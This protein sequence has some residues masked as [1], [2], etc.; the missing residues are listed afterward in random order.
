LC[1]IARAAE[2]D[3]A[4]RIL[5]VTGAHTKLVYQRRFSNDP[6]VYAVD[7]K[8]HML[9][10]FDTQEGKERVLLPGPTSCVKPSILSDG[11]GVVYTDVPQRACYY[12][13]WEGKNPPKLIASGKL[14]FALSTWQDPKTGKHWVLVGDGVERGTPE[15]NPV[16]RYLI[17]DPTQR[18]LVWDKTSV[19][20]CLRLS[21]DGTRLGGEF[22]WP[23]TGVANLLTGT[24]V[25]HGGGCMGDMAPDN[26]YRYAHC[27]GGHRALL[28]FDA[29]ATGRRFVSTSG[30]P[31][32]TGAGEN[33]HPRWSNDVRFMTMIAPSLLAYAAQFPSNPCVYLGKYDITFS[34]IE[35]WVQLTDD[36]TSSIY[37]HA[38][39]EPPPNQE[40]IRV[41]EGRLA[42]ILETA[43]PVAAIRALQQ[44]VAEGKDAAR[45][46]D[47]REMLG[48]FNKWSEGKLAVGKVLESSGP[49]EA[50]NLYTALAERY[51]G[52]ELG[53]QAA[54]RLKLL[55][56]SWA[57]ATKRVSTLAQAWPVSRDGLLFR[58]ATANEPAVAL[59]DKDKPK[60]GFAL[61]AHGRARL[62]R[63]R[64]MVLDGGS[65]YSADGVEDYLLRACRQ[66][67]ALTIQA[68]ITPPEGLPGMGE[69]VSFGVDAQTG[70]FALADNGYNLNLALR[71]ASGGAGWVP[72]GRK[73]PGAF[74]VA[75]TYTDGTLLVYLNGR[76]FEGGHGWG[77]NTIITESSA[78]AHLL[79]GG[80]ANWTAGRLT[81]GGAPDG[82]NAWRGLLEGVAIFNRALS[83]D[84]IQRDADAYRAM[85][86]ARNDFKPV[87]M[88]RAKVKLIARSD[89]PTIPSIAPYSRALVVYRYEVEDVHFGTLTAK[90]L[91]VA[92]WVIMDKQLLGEANAGIGTSYTMAL[93]PFSAQP[94]LESEYLVDTLN[95][96][97]DLYY[98][99]SGDFFG[100]R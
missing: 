51:A 76:R 92:R 3:L 26:S 80:F 44:S 50:V 18:V 88:V 63:S 23:K 85:V 99:T 53:T 9:V 90:N 8:N 36:T 35:Q 20:L 52:L 62:G 30:Y 25:A 56:T 84:E 82:K 29:G 70:N 79:T 13:D 81:F 72:V 55:D 64:H 97:D 1:G 4:A 7:D 71:T 68:Y 47:A 41:M 34:R 38:W 73:P 33:W 54:G 86:K 40:A 83:A 98:D 32:D 17:D 39:I 12:I 6:K 96:K 60:I 37:P 2:E 67:G 75:L 43:D 24:W 5:K 57:S 48:L 95:A 14:Y 65:W 77:N 19:G 22:P 46:N 78:V 89:I 10:V 49:D 16:Y 66:T 45:V 69:I 28:M 61:T 31:G 21:A 93:E 11:S 42:Q 27:V 100:V 87:P 91:C 94:Q 15:N 58:W 74:H 59:L